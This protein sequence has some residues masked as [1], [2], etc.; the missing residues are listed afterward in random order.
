MKPKESGISTAHNVK[1]KSNA[2][3]PISLE[4]AFND[5]NL[6]GRQNLSKVKGQSKISHDAIENVG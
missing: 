3:A 6:S 1:S 2:V 4:E 5:D